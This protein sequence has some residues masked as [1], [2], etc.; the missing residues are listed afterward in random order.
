MKSE[1]Y[2]R[3]FEIVGFERKCIKYFVYENKFVPILNTP[4]NTKMMS[5]RKNELIFWEI[6]ILIWGWRETKNL[7]VAHNRDVTLD[8]RWRIVKTRAKLKQ[9]QKIAKPTADR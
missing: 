6:P 3:Q 8:T 5:L 9:N 2:V 7:K 4:Q 1:K